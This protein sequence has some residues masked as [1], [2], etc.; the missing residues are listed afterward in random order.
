M[1]NDFFSYYTISVFLT[2][3]PL[4]LPRL[5][6]SSYMSSAQHFMY[7]KSLFISLST[8]QLQHHQQTNAALHW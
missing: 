8:N 4:P 7:V 5:Y 2:P 3:P 1:K 6:K